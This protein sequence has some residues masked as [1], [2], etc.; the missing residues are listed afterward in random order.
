MIADRC[1]IFNSLSSDHSSASAGRF[2]AN[3]F[4]WYACKKD[5]E[6]DRLSFIL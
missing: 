6:F 1:Q 4:D 2:L 5:V 3:F